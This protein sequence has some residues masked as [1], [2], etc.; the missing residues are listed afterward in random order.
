MRRLML[1][2]MVLTGLTL[3][4]SFSE[5]SQSAA[6][7]ENIDDYRTGC[8]IDADRL[9]AGYNQYDAN[10]FHFLGPTPTPDSD[11]RPGV[12]GQATTGNGLGE[13][14]SSRPPGCRRR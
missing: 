9:I 12:N 11:Y 4:C 10:R 8:E 14:L 2:I 6:L 3:G 7:P 1:A 13:W 5:Y